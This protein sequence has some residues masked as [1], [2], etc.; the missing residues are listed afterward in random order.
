MARDRNEDERNGGYFNKHE[1]GKILRNMMISLSSIAL[2]IPLYTETND[3]LKWH[4]FDGDLHSTD[5]TTERAVLKGFDIAL[6]FGVFLGILG[7]CL[8]NK[9]E[10]K[11]LG[12]GLQ[13]LGLAVSTI[14]NIGIGGIS[15]STLV[16]TNASSLSISKSTNDELH[17]VNAQLKLSAAN[18]SIPLIVLGLNAKLLYDRMNTPRSR[19]ESEHK[20]AEI[21]SQRAQARLA[22][23]T[24]ARAEAERK[25][26]HATARAEELANRIRRID[27]E[28]GT[29]TSNTTPASPARTPSPT[30]MEEL[31][32]IEEV[33]TPTF[34][35]RSHIIAIRPNANS[36]PN[37]S[38]P[39]SVS[40][41]RIVDYASLEAISINAASRDSIYRNSPTITILP[42]STSAVGNLARQQ[43][44][45]LKN[46]TKGPGFM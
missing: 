32:S 40:P 9:T 10:Y 20:V 3:N 44:S 2:A 29:L 38:P 17:A 36:A 39:R 6:C 46:E 42:S 13:V 7:I 5:Q 12:D 8:K 28:D 15:V 25:A 11:K 45:E 21:E 23:L 37:S 35:N 26:D 22:E 24:I 18:L 33:K 41:T 27:T 30:I 19:V 4:D 1:N 16:N 43:E 31:S 14:S 34:T